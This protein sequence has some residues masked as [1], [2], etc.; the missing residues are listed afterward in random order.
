MRLIRFGEPGRERPGVL[1]PGGRRLD[2][3]GFGED[4]DEAFFA[5]D[6]LRRLEDWLNE[7]ESECPVVPETVRLG[8]CIA[9]PSKIVCI[10]LNYAGHVKETGATTPTE[11]VVF[12]KATTSLCGPYDDLVIPP[13]SESTDWEVE[14]AVI[15][16]RRARYVPEARAMDHVAG[17]ALHNDYSER[18][19]QM[20]RG[21]QWVK[22]KS[23]DTFAPFGPWLA[24]REELPDPHALGVWLEVN[25]ERLQ[26][27]HTSDLIFGVPALVS[28]LSHFMTLLPGDVISTG[29]PAGVGLGFD[30]PRYLKPGDV[31][32]LHIEGLGTSRQKA[33]AF[34]D[35]AAVGGASWDRAAGAT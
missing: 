21:G 29:T 8:P 22:G 28:H 18:H 33:V 6:G 20:E 10:G 17:Y 25:G 9:R 19:W 13:G 30:P 31:V 16:G 32:E 7:H 23:F 12:F 24:T 4:W 27:S 11:P 35:Q 14:L 15:I 3:G 26:E 5:S 1:A 2:A 34:E